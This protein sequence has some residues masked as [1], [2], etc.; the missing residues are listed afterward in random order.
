MADSLN[1]QLMR[2]IFRFKKLGISSLPELGVNLAE[3]MLMTHVSENVAYSDS[4]FTMSNIHRCM[5]VSKPAVSQILG[6]LEKKGFICR[7]IDKF[8][9]RKISVELTEKGEESL[10]RAKI[11]ADHIINNVINRFGEQ[12][13]EQLISLLSQFADISE[14]MKKETHPA[15]EKG[16]DQP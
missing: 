12:N 5:H 2:T 11:H 13:T 15:N 8:D 3:L 7:S 10:A 1:E 9:R 14:E 6:S 16:D 4:N